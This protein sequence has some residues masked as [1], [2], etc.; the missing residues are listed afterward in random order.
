M[1]EVGK[2]ITE[3]I[4]KEAQQMDE[5]V[6]SLAAMGRETPLQLACR[7]FECKAKGLWKYLKTTYTKPE[8]W[9]IDC[10]IQR[11]TFFMLVQSRESNKEMDEPDF[12][13][14][15][16]V[17]N[18]LW[19]GRLPGKDKTPV[20][21][22]RAQKE[23]AED[24]EQEVRKAQADNGQEPNDSRVTMKI[25]MYAGQRIAFEGA[26]KDFIVAH[27]L[28]EDDYGRAMELISTVVT[29]DLGK[30]QNVVVKISTAMKQAAFELSQL[31][32]LFSADNTLSADETLKQLHDG[33][34]KVVGILAAASGVSLKLAPASQSKTQT[35]KPQTGAEAEAN[36]KGFFKGR[37]GPTASAA[38]AGVSVSASEPPQAPQQAAAGAGGGKAAKVPTLT[39]EQL[40]SLRVQ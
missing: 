18:A 14:F 6:R 2:E 31:N 16:S 4:R 39:S 27:N 12:L 37:K 15:K 11:A 30:G 28:E 33:F 21:F 36:A 38:A 23:N 20:M 19:F 8:E 3:A 9:A 10:G 22:E 35:D 7:L 26:M 1:S 13:K 29:Q 34:E 24:F 25:R 32:H 40:G 5:K 17:Q